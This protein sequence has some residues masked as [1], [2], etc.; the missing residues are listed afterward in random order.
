[1]PLRFVVLNR[2][3]TPLHLFHRKGDPLMKITLTQPKPR[4]PLAVSA[5]LRHAGSHRPQQAGRRQQADRALRRELIDVAQRGEL[6]DVAQRG[7]LIDVAQRGELDPMKHS[8]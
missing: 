1:M 2:R 4:N 7:E 3:A 6:I 8:P 5:R